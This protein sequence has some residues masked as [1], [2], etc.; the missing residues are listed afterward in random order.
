MKILEI[1]PQLSQGGAERFVIDLCNDMSKE[2]EVVL[3]VLHNVDNHGFFRKELSKQVRLISMNKRMGMD[4]QLFF[5]LAK[6]IREEKPDVVHTHLRGIVYTF[7]SYIF[8]SKIKFIHTVHNDAKMEAGGG[9]S[10]WCRELAFNLKRVH[11][12]TISEE[13]QRSF[14]EFYHL[15][16]TL[17]YNGRPEYNFN[18]DISAVQQELENI[19]T[20]KQAKIIVNIARIQPQKNQLPLAKAIDNLNKQGYA[21]EL[22]II[23]SKAD[24]QIVNNIEALHSPYVH[25]LD[26]RT[27]PRDYMRA[28]DAFCLSSIYEGMPI[29]LI[30][31][32]SVGAIP[33][34]TPVGGIVNMIQ[35]SENGLLAQSSNQEG[36]EQILQRF[37]ELKDETITNMK[38]KSLKTFERFNMQHCC[39]Q[40]ITTINQL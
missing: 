25:L 2:H 14:E 7:L 17:I 8:T 13:S 20:N 26:A 32:F 22:A 15:P 39:Q 3:V 5:R 21:V 31:C 12:V 36:I 23:G 18:T 24:K 40:Y 9:V 35:D 11:P 28:A 6:L 10:K 19:K 29:T 33:L 37:L 16:S 34:C 27:N 4:W 1:I 38:D 30:E